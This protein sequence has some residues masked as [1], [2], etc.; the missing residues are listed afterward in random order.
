MAKEDILVV[1][2]DGT[3]IKSDLLWESIFL[4]VK[5][6]LFKLFL[7]PFWL[8]KGG[9]AYLKSKLAD[10]VQ[11]DVSRLPY[12]ETLIDFLKK[13]KEEGKQLVLASA[14][15]IRLVEKV[16]GHLDL[17]D[18][19][20][21]TTVGKN[22][23]GK[24]KLD[25]IKKI[26]GGKSFGYVGNDTSDLVIWGAAEKAYAVTDSRGFIKALKGK[27]G[28]ATIFNRDRD[29]YAFLKVLRLHQWVKNF[30]IFI[31]LF[32]AHQVTDTPKL[33]SCIIAFFLFSICASALYIVNDLFD[34]EA[35]RH[36]PKKYTRPLASGDISI[37][38]GLVL[39]AVCIIACYV[40]C[41][42]SLRVPF[43][44]LLSLYLLLSLL[45][46]LILKTK[47]IIDVISLSVLYS[48]R[49]FA[50]GVA[51][52]V[53]VSPWLL[54][55]SIFFFLCLAFLKRFV[56]LE[57]FKEK[58]IEELDGR[59]YCVE[60]ISLVQTAGISSGFISILVFYLYITN[61]EVVTELYTQPMFLWAVGPLLIYWLIR[62][63]V[64]AKRGLVDSDPVFF[65]VK[66]AVSW[67][68]GAC[69]TLLVVLGASI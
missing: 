19:Y 12:F 38:T 61:S 7:I 15:E 64:K 23:K 60:D 53:S 11:P 45:Y 44:L 27:D 50:G 2:L 29:R 24:I 4:L 35:D 40:M 69:V 33:I 37:L 28:D 56:E 6:N 47:M 42:Y 5:K 55:F 46:S 31:P 62:L 58:H 49:I 14:S 3:L 43:L 67:I 66:D 10:N 52:D 65:A 26:C 16:A 32:L 30:L 36:H 41:Y 17:F 8:L 63:W 9:K 13:S 48:F 59:D 57:T 20:I 68:V 22:L 1:D 18:R 34:L 51:A 25:E 39:A 21:G 54:A